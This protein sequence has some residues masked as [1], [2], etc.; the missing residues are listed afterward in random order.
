MSFR[1]V[2]FGLI[3]IMVVGCTEA[4]EPPVEQEA[5]PPG[6]P[7]SIDPMPTLSLGVLEGD[8]LQEFYRI[9]TPFLLGGSR[10]AVPLQST[11]VIRVFDLAGKHIDDL[12]RSG[13]GPGEFKALG[14]AW[15]RGDTIEAFDLN[16]R[17]ITRFPPDGEVEV[18]Q[19]DRVPSAQSITP[20]GSARGW[21]SYGVSSIGMDGRDVWAVHWF[22]RDGSHRGEVT[23]VEGFTRA[24]LDGGGAVLH[25][26][27]PR[28]YFAVRDT[29]VYVGESS[30][31]TIQ[32]LIPSGELTDQIE[33]GASTFSRDQLVSL[34][35]DSA[36]A[37][38]SSED[39]GNVRSRFDDMGAVKIPIAWDVLIDEL[40][41][42]WV[43]RFDPLAHA[44]ILGG[45][46][47]PGTGG[48]WDIF[49]P[50]GQ[51]VGVVRMPRD[52]EPTQ[53]TADY[54]VG[55][56]EDDLGVETVSIHRLTR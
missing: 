26:I 38:A 11:N 3:S 32:L 25:P 1:S 5:R 23:R 21:L 16:T 45:G 52:L 24:M 39:V 14:P 6:A 20:G 29:I 46:L 47:G 30:S 22:D 31:S 41:Y 33:L 49:D 4:P 43:R 13:E 53:I 27:S 54:V 10:L 34:V 12:G 8:T 7:R 40:G 28:A 19:L 36:V 35:R 18:I 2:S 50:A 44:T 51:F 15:Q 17:R 48:D 42:L 9:T 37:R 56:G 55:K